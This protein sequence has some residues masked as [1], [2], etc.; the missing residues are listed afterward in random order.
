ML[1]KMNPGLGAEE[2]INIMNNVKSAFS[3]SQNNTSNNSNKQTINSSINP[4]KN[5]KGGRRN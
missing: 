5:T 4:S 2:S 1:N 3:I